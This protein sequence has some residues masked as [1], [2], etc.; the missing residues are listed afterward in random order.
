MWEGLQSFFKLG[1]RNWHI[2][3]SHTFSSNSSEG[4]KRPF[5]KHVISFL[6]LWLNSKQSSSRKCPSRPPQPLPGCR[7]IFIDRWQEGVGAKLQLSELQLLLKSRFP[8]KAALSR[9]SRPLCGSGDPQ[10]HSVPVCLPRSDL[11]DY[12]LWWWKRTWCCLFTPIMRSSWVSCIKTELFS[13]V[14]TLIRRTAAM[15]GPNCLLCECVTVAEGKPTRKD[16][17]INRFMLEF[18]IW[19]NLLLRLNIV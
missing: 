19:C 6:A 13:P 18:L 11:A 17:Y 5:S 14:T 2:P 10:P 8:M 9:A 3:A 1:L 7:G 12:P 16:K 4:A 15:L